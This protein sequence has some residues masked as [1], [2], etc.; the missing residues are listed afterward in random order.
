MY[1]KADGFLTIHSFIHKFVD[2]VR[3]PPYVLHFKYKRNGGHIDVRMGR[4]KDKRL[5]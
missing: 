2:C 3:G 4:N 5:L 1:K